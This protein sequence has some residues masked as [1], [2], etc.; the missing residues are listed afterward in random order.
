MS[1]FNQAVALQA[2][3]LYPDL[4]QNFNSKQR[5]EHKLKC[6]AHDLQHTDLYNVIIKQEPK[7]MTFHNSN[8]M[9]TIRSTEKVNEDKSQNPI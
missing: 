3:N 4:D 7:S 6:C 9:P 2:S 1:R 8:I 5:R